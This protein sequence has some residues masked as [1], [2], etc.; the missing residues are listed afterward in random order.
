MKTADAAQPEDPSRSRWLRLE[1]SYFRCVGDRG[2]DALRV[3]V[4]DVFAKQ[5]SQVVLTQNHD[6]IEQLSTNGAHE[7]LGRPVLPGAPECRSSGLD[8]ESRNRGGDVFR[9]DR[10]VVEDQESMNGFAGESI[11]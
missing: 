11:P 9:E 2:V 5:P 4:R 3:V 6:M 7:A 8:S 10:I 1:R